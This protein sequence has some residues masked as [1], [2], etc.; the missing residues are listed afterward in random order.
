MINHTE[1]EHPRTSA[2]RAKC[3]RA[4]KSGTAPK[5]STKSVDMRDGTPTGRP[6][7]PSLRE[8]Q[9]DGC[10]VERIAYRGHDLLTGTLLSVGEKCYYMVKNDPNTMPLD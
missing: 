10:G 2:A 3:R 4:Q 6:R 5:A 7:T 9:C 1:C 8:L